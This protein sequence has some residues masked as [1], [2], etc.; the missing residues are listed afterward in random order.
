MQTGTD[1]NKFLSSFFL[2]YS[3]G[4]LTFEPRWQVVRSRMKDTLGVRIPRRV[5]LKKVVRSRWNYLDEPLK[6]LLWLRMNFEIIIDWRVVKTE[7]WTKGRSRLIII[8][9]FDSC[10][11]QLVNVEVDGGGRNG[12][13]GFSMTLLTTGGLHET[14]TSANSLV[15]Q[16]LGSSPMCLPTKTKR[17]AFP[18][19]IDITSSSQR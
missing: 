8:F 3:K 5:C 19:V 2:I 12:H 13:G 11:C 18:L 1:N 10:D 6:N 7:Q 9:C 14:L 15:K 17:R 16:C 4:N